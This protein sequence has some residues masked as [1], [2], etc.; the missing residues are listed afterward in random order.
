MYSIAMTPKKILLISHDVTLA[1]L[2][3][4]LQLA[5]H[6][7]EAGHEVILASS[8]DSAR[9]I[10]SFPGRTH[11]L[12]PTGKARFIDNLAKGR[13]VFDFETLRCFAEEDEAMLTTYR[14]DLVIGDFRISLSASAR[15]QQV[16]YATITNAY[17]SPAFAP[18]FVVPD[19]PMVKHLGVGI[20][21]RLFDLARPFAFAYHCRP[22]NAL[23][24]HY[25]LP[26]LGHDLRRVYTDADLVLFSDVPE[27]YGATISPAG[28]GL[29]LGPIQWSPD[30][31]LPDWW[32]QLDPDTPTIYV[33]LGSSGD[34]NLLP[35]LVESLRR[36]GLQLIVASAGAPGVSTAGNVFCA[37]YLPGDA[38]AAR[39]AL[40]VCNGGSP[41]SSQALAHGVPVLG[42]PSNLDQFLNMHYLEKWGAAL[43]LRRHELHDEIIQGRLRQLLDT[44]S[45]RD[46]AQRLAQIYTRYDASAIVRGAALDRLLHPS[47]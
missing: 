44:P 22:M 29:F 31:P 47:H 30:I 7:I 11:L 25:G 37:D 45:Y 2:G 16:P 40:V 43:T 20:S 24:R 46:A 4:P 26:S 6:L 14:P 33:T 10:K 18:H 42:I 34:G 35:R 28:N 32:S 12:A 8:A 38:A 15:R 36:T 17:W 23:R 21:Q 1:H 9:F 39:S 27:L 41:T 19:L 3:R 5:G 13:P